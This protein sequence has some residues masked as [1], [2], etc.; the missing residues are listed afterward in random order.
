MDELTLSHELTQFR[1]F[2]SDTP[3]PSAAQTEAARARLLDAIAAHGR[4]VPRPVR[5]RVW[6]GRFTRTRF[7]APVAAAAA[8]TAV[9]ITVALLA[10]PGSGKPSPHPSPAA[11]HRP[12][13][14][15]HHPGHGTSKTG[16][17]QAPG[18]GA[19]GSASP[20]AAGAAG[21]AGQGTAGTPGS[22]GYGPPTPTTTTLTASPEAVY[23]V[24]P[25]TLTA[26]VTDQGRSNL[27]GGTVS[28]WVS[29]AGSVAPASALTVCQ[30]APVT[31]DA[32]AGDNTATCDFTPTAGYSGSYTV[33]AGYTG[34]RQY[35]PS[36]SAGVPLTITALATVTTLTSVSPDQASPGQTV[37]LT[38][39]VTD[40]AGDNLSGGVMAF[41]WSGGPV[42]GISPGGT[43]VMC[44]SP[45]TY[46]S[47]THDNV[48]TCQYTIPGA[49]TAGILEMQAAYGDSSGPYPG[50][51]SSTV[52]F[53][54]DG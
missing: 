30:S 17:G 36:D 5:P 19:A 53:T 16:T 11:T 13:H 1:D 25:V 29:L 31:Y 52:P 40:Q 9:A 45:L 32:T 20:G 38:A 46:D 14:K 24:H 37:T 10:E 34:Y 26:T 43:L 3:G 50:S 54:V 12:Q 22:S 42:G 18:T 35:E 7:W 41:V 39:A 23:T 48:A 8:V 49:M 27:S 51:T 28:F 6:L 2:R 47:A 33:G 4:A 44:D 21:A 15:K